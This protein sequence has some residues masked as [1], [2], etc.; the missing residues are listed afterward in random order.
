MIETQTDLVQDYKFPSL[1]PTVKRRIH[2]CKLTGE[3]TGYIGTCE[4]WTH[5]NTGRKYDDSSS[6][7]STKVCRGC[8]N[9]VWE[10]S[11]K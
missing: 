1:K 6:I 8:K 5:W 4:N 9:F 10:G 2:I 11:K 7:L 3:E